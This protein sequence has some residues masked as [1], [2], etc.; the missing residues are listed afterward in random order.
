MKRYVIDTNALISFVTDRNPE[1]QRIVA[2]LFEAAAHMKAVILCHQSVL[3]EFIYVLDKVY[4]LPKHRIGQMI[5]DLVQMPGMQLV[6]ELDYQAVLSVWPDPFPDFGDAVV[7]SVALAKKGA[8]IVT[9][10]RKFSLGL[11][12]LNIPFYP[13]RGAHHQNIEQLGAE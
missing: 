9:F 5:I 11:N 1:Q 7:A 2:P 8:A 6:Q 12:R 13:A 3:T 10:D 4:Q